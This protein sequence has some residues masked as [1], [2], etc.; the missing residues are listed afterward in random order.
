MLLHPIALAARALAARGALGPGA[1]PCYPPGRQAPFVVPPFGRLGSA[2]RE[3]SRP[4]DDWVGAMERADRAEAVRVKGVMAP[5]SR[6]LSGW[7]LVAL[8]FTNVC[9]AYAV[10]FS[11][12]VFLP[13]LAEEFHASRGTVAAAFSWAMLMIGVSSMAVGPALDR[14][15]PRR[16]FCAGAVVLG[17]GMCLAALARS[18][19]VLYVGFGLGGGIGAS[20]LGWVAHGALLG[21]AKLSRPTTAMGVAFGGMGA[22][23][24]VSSPIAQR[25]IAAMGWRSALALMGVVACL[26]LLVLNV[27]F[28]PSGPVGHGPGVAAPVRGGPGQFAGLRMALA[29]PHFWLYFV[30]FFTIGTG[31]FSVVAHQV[32]YVVD[33]GFAPLFAA[34][35]FGVTQVLS[36]VGRVVFGLLTDRW[37]QSATFVASFGM[38]IAGIGCLLLVQHPESVWF[39]YAFVALFGISFGARGPIMTMMAAGHFGGPAFGTIF[40]A[41]SLAHGLGTGLGPWM[42]GVLFDR[43]GD[44]RVTFGLA[45]LSLAV[46]C[47]VTL[48]L[49]RLPRPSGIPA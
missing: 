3:V 9:I 12:P 37:G 46:A 17:T 47:G 22:G 21:R 42:A 31:M 40:G 41:I 28:H 33:R 5:G 16:T 10:V 8:A 7:P 43:T 45:M 39:L 32:A 13:V 48:S 27:R 36:G 15:G 24:L 49:S 26:A 20:F 14:W 34:S 18:I 35:V 11:F 2:D 44:Y 23:P 25:L 29:T 4:T 6:R 38:S 1:S 19:W 30:A